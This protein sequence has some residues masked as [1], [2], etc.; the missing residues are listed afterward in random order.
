MGT[1]HG[2]TAEIA[3]LVQGFSEPSALSVLVC[4][5]LEIHSLQ[6]LAVLATISA[7]VTASDLREMT[8]VQCSSPAAELA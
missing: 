7:G 3:F 1:L 2:M 8:I 5:V 4:N 6:T